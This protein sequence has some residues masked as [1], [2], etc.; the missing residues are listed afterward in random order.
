MESQNKTKKQLV[1]ELAALRQ[2]VPE[3]EASVLAHEQAEA[4]W[5]SL[6][7]NAPEKITILDRDGTVLFVNR[8]SPGRTVDEV[9]GTKIYDY[10][11]LDEQDRV[12]QVL[13]SVF[14]SGQTERYETVDVGD[15]SRESVYSLGVAP[16]EHEG[17]IAAAIFIGA[18]ITAHKHAEEALRESEG[19]ARALLD[20]PTDLVTLV[21]TNGIILSANEAMAQRFGKHKDEFIG[22]CGWDL[23]PPGLVKSRKAYFEQVIQSGEPRSFEDERQGMWFDNVFYPAFDAHGKV[24][25]IAVIARDITERKRIEEALQESNE[26]LLKAQRLAGMGFLDWNLKTGEMHWSDEVYNLY[27]VDPQEEKASIDMTMRL[28]HPDDRE[29]VEKNLEMAFQGIKEYDI[30]HRKL[31]PDGEVIWVQAQAELVRDDD[32]N[33]ESLLGTVIDITER[34]RMEEQIR[35]SLREKE[36][37]LGEIHH[38]VRNNLQVICALLD[39]QAYSTQDE[40]AS[41]AL[42]ETRVRVG[43]MALVHEQL[44]R[45]S[46]LAQID[47][48]AY[49]QTLTF[50]L[51]QAYQMVPGH[52][53]SKL[54]VDDAPLEVDKAIPCGFIINELV[55]NALKHAFPLDRE[56]ENEIYIAF[57]RTAEDEYELVV[58]DNGVGLPVDFQFP[59]RETVGMLLI[60]AYSREL[61]ATVEWQ[62]NGD[63]T[64]RV[65]FSVRKEERA[66]DV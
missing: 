39:L 42:R 24:S 57:H 58:R 8:T 47:F 17:K 15:D 38:R 40:Q 12:R 52:V 33:P 63:T 27:G 14:Q 44:Y 10:L 53:T 19:I 49:V 50:N 9:I 4:R 36:V 13:E 3:L 54:D 56:G 46:N 60:G 16:I 22:V 1:R 37:M 61:K 6:A 48:A 25:K 66:A 21:D 7:E 43:S 23:L 62:S 55:T 64:C 41:E 29:F 45:A 32:G 2:R 20:A 5:R 30:D 11:P 51:F 26:R 59:T 31:R 65:V 35:A 18:D 28:I 34:K